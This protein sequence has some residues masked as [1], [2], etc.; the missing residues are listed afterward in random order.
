MKR[1]KKKNYAGSKTLPASIKNKETHWPEVPWVSPTKILSWS[2]LVKITAFFN[3]KYFPQGVI[4]PQAWIKETE[5]EPP[6][7]SHQAD[8]NPRPRRVWPD[9]GPLGFQGSYPNRNRMIVGKVL[10]PLPW[11]DSSSANVYRDECA[12]VYLQ[13]YVCMCVYVCVYV[14]VCVRVCVCVCACDYHPAN[15]ASSSRP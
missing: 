5:S 11:A 9:H 14:C 1:K 7:S 13:I 6:D 2:A 10:T 12:C 15:P 8:S 3:K 4:P